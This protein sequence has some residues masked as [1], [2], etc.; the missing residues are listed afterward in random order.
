MA[1][2]FELTVEARSD[3]GKGASRRLRREASRLPAIIY[4]A[5]KKPEM[6]SLSQDDLMHALENE[7]FYSHILTLNKGN[8][9]ES[10]V[11]KALQRH[12]YKKKILHADFLR[13]KENEELQML[14]PLHFM[15]EES[16]P[17]VKI[18]GGRASHH[19]TEVEVRCLPGDL[20]EFIN[21]DMS[22]LELNDS[23]S[24][25]QLQL[26]KG[27]KLVDLIHDAEDDLSVATISAPR[28][29][30]EVD[31]AAAPTAKETEITSAKPED[32]DKSGEKK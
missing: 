5:D 14:I 25:S 32:E 6:I 23:I 2:T 16:A 20:P 12:P 29:V 27:V 21:V 19:M 10:V 30:E 28:K 13:I 9:K 7:A 31:D 26:P 3:V 22:A 24:L 4:G 17:G 8:E 11:L 18:A 15:G 1:I